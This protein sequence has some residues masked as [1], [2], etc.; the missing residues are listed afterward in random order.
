[1]RA[2]LAGLCRTL[3]SRRNII[4]G[5]LGLLLGSISGYVLI[6]WSNRNSAV[7]I[8]DERELDGSTTRNGSLDI[9]VE[10]DRSRD[11]PAETSRWLWTWVEHNGERIKQFYPLANSATTITDTGLDQHFILSIPIPPG[12]WPG[13]WFYWSKTTEHCSFLPSLFRPQV[14]ESV[15]I[16]VR[17]REEP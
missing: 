8:R 13:E 16:P 7:I 17:I 11:C 9:Y 6:V 12:V 4:A 10:L 1:M 2:F 3:M 14:R 15:D 5:L